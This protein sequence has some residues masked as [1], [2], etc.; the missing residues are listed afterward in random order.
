[1]AIKNVQQITLGLVVVILS[2]YYLY[3]QLA[4]F[5]YMSDV[6]IA[7]IVFAAGLIYLY[8]NLSVK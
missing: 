6:F 3:D 8:S 2:S 1:M 5:S 4:R 7:V